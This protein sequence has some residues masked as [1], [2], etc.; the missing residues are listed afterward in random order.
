MAM[1]RYDEVSTVS[2]KAIGAPSFDWGHG[3]GKGL[4][5]VDQSARRSLHH[6]KVRGGTLASSWLGRTRARRGLSV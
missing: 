4:N 6:G 5:D 3:E 2:N 1:V